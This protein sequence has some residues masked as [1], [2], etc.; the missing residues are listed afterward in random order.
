MLRE[1]W[2]QQYRDNV[3]ENNILAEITGRILCIMEDKPFGS[4]V[5]YGKG[6]KRYGTQR[7]KS[8]GQ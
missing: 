2:N 8:T 7:K 1:Q 5:R 4:K 3:P 6:W